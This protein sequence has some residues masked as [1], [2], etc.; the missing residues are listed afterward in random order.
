M[1]GPIRPFQVVAFG[2]KAADVGGLAEGRP[3]WQRLEKEKL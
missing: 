2:L 1:A 3:G